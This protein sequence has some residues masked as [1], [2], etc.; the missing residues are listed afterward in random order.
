[1]LTAS[2]PEP[3]LAALLAAVR[4]TLGHSLI[5]LYIHGSLA[6]G[7]F[8][9]ERSDIDF[10]ALVSDGFASKLTSA[11]T[12]SGLRSLHQDLVASGD[13][14]ACRLEG[15]Y[16]PRGAVRRWDPDWP[17]FPSLR[18]D[19]SFDLDRH[20]PD[21]PIQLHVVREHGIALCGS[22]PRDLI[23]PVAPGDLRRAAR[24]I[25]EAWWVPQL[26]DSRRLQ[27]SEYRAYAVLT[28]CRILYTFE[29]GAVA[30]K[31]AAARW[32]ESRLGPR[33]SALID[34]ALAWGHGRTWGD[35]DAVLDFIRF[36]AGRL[37]ADRLT[38]DRLAAAESR[39][40]TGDER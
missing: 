3:T 25:L 16:L 30:A 33:W 18:A 4:R 13:R 32:A 7:A 10:L 29:T 34:G 2:G 5:G 37:T 19:G 31:P 28:M 26:A 6:L 38:A 14:W 12:I 24:D 40:E 21:W 8:D 9:P 27:A 15:S 22:P 35:V 1:M 20:G 11:A 23:D 17:P 39:T 36:T